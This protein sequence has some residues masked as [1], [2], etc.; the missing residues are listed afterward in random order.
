MLDDVREE[1]AK[2][3]VPFAIVHGATMGQQNTLKA[4]GAHGRNP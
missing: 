4:R 3:G 1:M 2:L